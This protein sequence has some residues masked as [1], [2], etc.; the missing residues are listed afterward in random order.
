VVQPEIFS[1]MKNRDQGKIRSDRPS[2]RQASEQPEH[3]GGGTPATE[4]LHQGQGPDLISQDKRM[5]KKNP[6]VRQI[7]KN[8][9]F[10]QAGEPHQQ[11]HTDRTGKQKL[12]KRGEDLHDPE[13]DM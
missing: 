8:L 10:Q 12:E 5:Q 1:I 9:G 4:S 11:P 7:D 2:G 6:G 3:S 13:G